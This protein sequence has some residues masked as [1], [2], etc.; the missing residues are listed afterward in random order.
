MQGV[1]KKSVVKLQEER[2]VRKIC[3]LDHHVVM[4]FV[5][6]TTEARILIN[7]AQVQCQH[8]KIFSAEISTDELLGNFFTEFRY[9]ICVKITEFW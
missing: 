7:R 4:A 1:E 3:L 6:L 8:S 5:G 2:T 9:F